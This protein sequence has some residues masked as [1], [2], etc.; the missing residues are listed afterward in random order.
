M[1]T[2]E[3]ITVERVTM[4]PGDGTRY[5]F[6]VVRDGPDEFCFAPCTSTFRFPQRLN[7]YDAQRASEEEGGI[8]AIAEKNHCNPWTVVACIKAMEE[9][10]K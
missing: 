8:A 2:I 5:D 4:E 3:Q 1:C 7:W 6:V 9:L 10:R